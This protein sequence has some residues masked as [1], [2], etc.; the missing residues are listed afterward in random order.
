MRNLFLAALLVAQTVL[1]SPAIA[2]ELRPAFLELREVAQGDFVV[3][4]K[5]PALGERR[6]ALY[7]KLP[8]TCVNEGEKIGAFKDTAFFERWKARCPDG[9]KGQTVLIEGLRKTMTDVLAH[10]EYLG[11]AT[12]TVRLTPESPGFMASGAQTQWDVFRTYLKLGVEHI[13]SGL[14]HLLFVLALLLLIRD[15][16]M[17]VKTITAFTVA[18]SITL[19]G[20]ALGYLSFPQSPV[21]ATIALSIAIVASEIAKTQSG[22]PRTSETYPW[23]IAFAFGLL[24]GFGFAGALKEIGL[25]QQNIPLALLSF[26]VGVEAGQLL[27]V[28]SLLVFFRAVNALVVVLERRARIVAAYVIGVI[29]TYWLLSRLEGLWV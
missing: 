29:S 21:E 5:V 8:A 15:R 23:L 16:W 14:D 2:H 4:W 7:V 24:H 10:I 25:P 1:V 20:S 17:L 18:H 11:G 9:I 19:A 3:T 28:A 22:A 13:L 27:F 12:Q 6:L 26:N